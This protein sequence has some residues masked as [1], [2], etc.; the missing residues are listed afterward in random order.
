M[1]VVNRMKLAL[2]CNVFLAVME[3]VA[4]CMMLFSRSEVALAAMGLYSLKY[5]TVLSNLLL[6]A[7]SL[8]YAVFIVRA[9]RGGARIPRWAYVLK[10]IATVAT[11]VTLMTVLLFLGPT[12]GYPPMFAGANLWFHL[13]LPVVAIVE[14]VFL[15]TTY[16]LSF[17]ET[18]VGMV[19]TFLYGLAYCGNIYLNGVGSGIGTNDWYGFTMW[20]VEYMPVVFAVMLLATWLFAVVIRAGNTLAGR[21]AGS[22]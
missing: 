20:G 21:R 19:S 6:G 11:T 17:K 5:F 12:L 14:F 10:Y 18:I 8:V 3:P 9:L 2:L 16:R 7:A 1:N 15:D 22:E 4:W 13:V